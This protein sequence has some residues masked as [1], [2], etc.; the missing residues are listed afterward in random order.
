MLATVRVSR[1]SAG[2]LLLLCLAVGNCA[3]VQAQSAA[4]I[5]QRVDEGQLATLAG[6]TRAEA[7]PENDRGIVADNLPM[8]H[9]L[10]Q[11]K[12]SPASEQAVER[13]IDQLYD[14]NSPNFHHWLTAEEFGRRFGLADQDLQ[15]I[16]GWLES[17]GLTV[18]TV[19]ASRMVIDFS[20]TAAQVREAFH[21]EIHNLDVN[22]VNHI[23]NMSDPRIPAA[24]Q[25][26][27]EGVVSLHDFRPYPM[28]KMRPQ[29]TF[30]SLGTTFQAVVPGDLATIYNFNPVFASGNTGQG[31]TIVLLEDTNVKSNAD[32]NTF[33]STFGLS[34]YAATFSQVQPS[35]CKSPGVN[36]DDI[37]AALDI[38]YAT[39][40]AP[41]AAIE[42]AACADTVSTFGGLTALQNLLNA[43]NP[44]P[45]V[46]MSYGECEAVT[47]AALNNMFYNA[48][49]QAAGLGV[50]VFVSAGDE[51][52][53]SCD[54]HQTQAT[55][56]ISVTG[57][58]ETPYNV[59]VGGT[60]FG[61]TYAGTN[62]TYWNSTNSATYESAKSYVPEIPWNDSCASVLLA[63]SFGFAT[64]YGPK[65]F[66]NSTTAQLDGFFTVAGGSGGPS[67]CATGA[68]STRGVVSGTC[69]G[70]SKPSWQT[71]V[72]VP[73]DGVR[74]IPD[75]SLF[76]A[77]GIWDHYYIFCDSD[78]VNGGTPCT[79]SPS[80]WS[81]AGGTSFSSP[82]LAGVQALIN[83]KAGSS[84]G[85]PNPV[86]YSLAAT[87]YGGAGN[88]SCNSTLGNAVASSC[89][90]YDVTQGDIDVNCAGTIN[91]Y[92][93]SARRGVLSTSDTAY[94][95]AYGTGVGWDFSTGIGTV[96]VANLVNAWPTGAPMPNFT[97]AASPATVSVTQSSSNTTTITITPQNGFSGNV[98][99][100]A[101]GLPS[102]VTSGFNPNPATS[103]SILTL[104]ASS[105]ATVG[106]V[107][108]TVTGTS[109][110][111]TNQTTFTLTVNAASSGNFSL[112]A[113]PTQVP[114]VPGGASGTSKITITPSGGFA[115]SVTLAASGLP[116]G[117]S[118]SFNPDPA[119]ST[120][121]LTLTAA[122]SAPKGIA[123]VTITGTSGALM[124]T[125][126][127]KVGVE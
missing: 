123:T 75:V 27:V 42:L 60:D 70:Y 105:T 110:T 16:T 97:L 12:R 6:N 72:G 57:W 94:Q 22:G 93:D 74:D 73:N 41:S 117:V 38:E 8:E 124:H 15:T 4:V 87:E 25:P 107:T 76:A 98:T 62:S 36:S 81:G 109:G 31:Q 77:N 88:A 55:H 121:T 32:W 122:S 103:S 91:C 37:E 115:G 92:L 69:A 7:T 102:G 51:D 112:S 106:T 11:L 120:S 44:P 67:G 125:T 66:C 46:S 29:Y 99:L 18:N 24:L 59:A 2:V 114:L 34:G 1:V 21:T 118:A 80:G 43:G 86:Y 10:L 82:I 61:D 28:I 64:T 58:G 20:G 65:G 3:I 39:A 14:P 90:F 104:T 79:G 108:V 116:S 48:F 127:I 47:G 84:Q 111:L 101:A 19:Y 26:A 113:S 71:L 119:T 17:H 13:F 100:S 35:G 96:N 126:T 49:Q 9:M 33:R 50:S 89:V 56:G 30:T 23:A 53:A 78:T 52:A 83:E 45:I 5:T 68:P 85:N 40:A 63:T 95:I 54:A